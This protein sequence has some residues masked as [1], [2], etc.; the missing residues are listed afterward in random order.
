MPT[1]S[2]LRTKL[3]LKTLMGHAA[4]DLCDAVARDQIPETVAL[5][6]HVAG[7]RPDEIDNLLRDIGRLWGT[8]RQAEMVTFKG[9]D[10]F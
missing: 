5:I 3:T 4:G 8:G 7:F 1:K 2:R 6:H 10:V 9:N